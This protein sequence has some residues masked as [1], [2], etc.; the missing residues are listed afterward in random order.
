MVPFSMFVRQQR[1]IGRENVEISYLATFAI[2]ILMT[3][4]PLFLIF[5][6]VK[7]QEPVMHIKSVFPPSIIVGIL[8]AYNLFLFL[9]F[10]FIFILFYLFYFTLFYFILFYF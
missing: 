5:F 3:V 7:R 9:F 1:E 8:W 10:Y 6:S 2:G 4:G